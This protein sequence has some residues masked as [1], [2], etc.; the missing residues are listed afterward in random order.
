M[1]EAM[2]LAEYTAATAPLT[3]AQRRTI[4][5]EALAC[6]TRPDDV[7]RLRRACRLTGDRAFHWEMIII[8]RS[9]GL[10]YRL[11]EPYASRFAYLPFRLE[12]T[13][14]TYLVTKLVPGATPAVRFGPG[15]EV[16]HW[17]D[18]PIAWA[19]ALTGLDSLPLRPMLTRLPPDEDAVTLTYIGLDGVTR[20]LREPWRVG[21]MPAPATPRLDLDLDADARARARKLLFRPDVVACE[22]GNTA[23]RLDRPVAVSAGDIATH[24]PGV[25]RARVVQTPHGPV[26]HL[27]IFTLHVADPRALPLE[28]QRLLTLLPPRTAIDVR[29]TTG[30]VGFAVPHV[31]I[32]A[33]ADDVIT[34]RDLL[35]GNADLIERAAQAQANTGTNAT[36]NNP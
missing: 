20:S 21:E 12:R 13:G 29:G 4:V 18:T 6:V 31:L 3:P 16:T 34:R 11:P 10:T 7:T 28:V 2:T 32:D 1:P 25:L 19:A 8:H 23:V 17:N 26:G 30:P 27:R 9:L 24:M 22:G 35:H 33:S 5:D 15:A 14:P 36:A